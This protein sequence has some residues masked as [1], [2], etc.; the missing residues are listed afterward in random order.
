M[1]NMINAEKTLVDISYIA[2]IEGK[3]FHML[4]VFIPRCFAI[5]FW[6]VYPWRITQQIR[7]LFSQILIVL[8]V[9]EP[10]CI[11]PLP[12]QVIDGYK[13]LALLYTGN[14]Y[15]SF[16]DIKTVQKQL[17]VSGFH[18]IKNLLHLNTR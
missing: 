7:A 3:F 14:Q 13:N 12:R 17:L 10:A 8:H 18:G 2:V 6:F 16:N 15:F 11:P 9:L 5:S 4:V 1:V